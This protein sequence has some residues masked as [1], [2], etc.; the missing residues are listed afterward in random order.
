MFGRKGQPE[1]HEAAQRTNL[2]LDDFMTRLMAQE[3][4][5]LDSTSRVLVYQELRDYQGPEITSQEELPARV[6]EI[7]DL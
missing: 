6:R 3:L 4:P 2:P 5:L 1:H 7:M